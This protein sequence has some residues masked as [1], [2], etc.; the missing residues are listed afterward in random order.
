MSVSFDKNFD[1]KYY[2]TVMLGSNSGSVNIV[3]YEL[4]ENV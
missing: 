3:S 2:F 1:R 4:W